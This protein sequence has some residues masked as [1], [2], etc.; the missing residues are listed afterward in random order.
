MGTLVLEETPGAIAQQEQQGILLPV[1]E[2]L[3]A[4]KG[5]T[6]QEMVSLEQE[7]LSLLHAG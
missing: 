6:T 7:N 1:K 4:G 2:G 5:D 3:W